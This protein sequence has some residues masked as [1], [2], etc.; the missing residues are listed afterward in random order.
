[1]SIEQIKEKTKEDNTPVED[2]LVNK[3]VLIV[4]DDPIF[5]SMVKAVLE[6]YSCNVKE[7]NNGLEGLQMLQ[8][9]LPD[10]LLCDLSMP[11]LN[12]LEFVEEVVLEYPMLPIIVISG[13]GDMQDVA[14]V[15]RLGAKD[16]LVKPISNVSLLV[17]SLVSA[18]KL[19]EESSLRMQDFSSQWFRTS[20]LDKSCTEELHW[21]LEHLQNEPNIGRELLFELL[22]ES[23]AQHGEWKLAYRLLQ[24]TD[25]MPLIFDY[26]WLLDGRLFFYLVDSQSG[27]ENSVVS[28]LLIRAFFNDFIRDQHISLDVISKMVESI[29]KGMGTM[30]ES[31]SISALF[32]YVDF[33]EQALF[34]LSAGLG[35]VWESTHSRHV[36]QIGELLTSER[37]NNKVQR[38]PIAKANNSLFLNCV[39]C[40]SFKMELNSF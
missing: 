26:E 22:P 32:G 35:A 23:D 12:G 10:V 34:I 14:K 28:C 19:S 25:G 8:H 20:D 4:D 37:S 15:L 16:F 17:K 36:L 40:S 31:E 33:A 27:G 18:L 30:E 1:M 9:S 21:H 7:A 11:I 5:R 38:F 39:G 29:E 6:S 13:T 3:D 24:S 2:L